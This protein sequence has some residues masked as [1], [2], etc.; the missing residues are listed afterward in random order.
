M[1]FTD[2]D[3][4][5]EINGTCL[6]D[7]QVVTAPSRS[8]GQNTF[9]T[10]V[11]FQGDACDLFAAS[12]TSFQ[13]ETADIAF[14]TLEKVANQTFEIAASKSQIFN[15][16]YTGLVH[17]RL[18]AITKTRDELFFRLALLEQAS[19]QSVDCVEGGP[20]AGQVGPFLK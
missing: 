19:K 2:P 18:K 20:Q 3:F 12:P 1:V 15:C 17:D 8:D 5:F 6:G 11:Q 4:V 10:F 7:L 14:E 13:S 9:I 16:G